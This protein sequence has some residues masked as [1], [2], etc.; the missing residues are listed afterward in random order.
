M[1]SILN[2]INNIL[3]WEPIAILVDSIFWLVVFLVGFPLAAVVALLRMV[4]LV[5]YYFLFEKQINPLDDEKKGTEY[6]VF[7]TGCDSGFGNQLVEPLTTRGFTVFA[8]CLQKDSLS[9]FKG[10]SLVIPLQVDVTSDKSVEEA[11]KMVQTWLSSAGKRKRYFHGLVNNAGIAR[12]GLIDWLKMADFKATMDVNCM[13]MI[14]CCK[15]FMPI[16]KKQAAA[17]VY[18]DSRIVNVI[19]SA[20]TFQGGDHLFS[21]YSASKHAADAFTVNLRLE[22]NHFGVHVTAINPTFHQTPMCNGASNE[23]MIK[24]LWNGLPDTTRDEYGEGELITYI[25]W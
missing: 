25:V 9:Q 17:G 22:M 18:K 13:G 5:V 24:S 2:T 23:K 8:G 6:A 19:S 1:V 21:A 15:E 14:R 20:G 4:Y 16:F 7:I 11:V 10:N 3:Q 12:V